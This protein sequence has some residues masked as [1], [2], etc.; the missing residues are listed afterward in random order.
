MKKHIAATQLIIESCDAPL[1]PCPLVQ[2]PASLAP[3]PITIPPKIATKILVNKLAETKSVHSLGIIIN[4]KDP[5]RFEE[6]NDPT[7]IPITNIHPQ[8]TFGVLI[9]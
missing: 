8:S 9:L 4:S 5:L 2:P 7:T 1:I 3:K 6:I